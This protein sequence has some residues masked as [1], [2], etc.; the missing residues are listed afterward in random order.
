MFL[1]T[2]EPFVTHETSNS[3]PN[4]A[5]G[6]SNG[7]ACRDSS[8]V[9]L[10]E[11]EHGGPVGFGYCVRHF[12]HGRFVLCERTVAGR[13]MRYRPEQICVGGILLRELC[14]EISL[15]YSF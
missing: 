3:P 9:N 11:G 4:P 13:E 6:S 14:D 5:L 8:E 2:C 1:M 12:W 15:K 7:L 10:V